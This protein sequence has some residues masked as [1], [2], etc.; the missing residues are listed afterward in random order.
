M[1]SVQR[2]GT[3]SIGKLLLQY[4]LPAVGGFLANALYQFI[5]RILVGRG[6]GTAGMAAVTIWR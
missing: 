5:D 3:D 4:S 1:D 6:V 2:Q